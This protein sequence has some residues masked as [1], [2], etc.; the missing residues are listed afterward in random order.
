MIWYLYELCYGAGEGLCMTSS[1][2]K[3]K[4]NFMLTQSIQS[5]SETSNLFFVCSWHSLLNLKD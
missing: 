4:L 2:L 5:V 1:I 3:H